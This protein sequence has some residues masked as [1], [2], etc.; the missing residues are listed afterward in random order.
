MLRTR[1]IS[2][3]A[4]M[5]IAL[6]AVY[7]GGI[8]FL[9]GSLLIALIAGWEFSRMMNESGYHTTPLLT[10]TLITLLLL[11]SYYWPY[12]HLQI[13]I[14]LTLIPSLI[15]QLFRKHTETQ[16]AD[17]ALT[18][19]GGFYVGWGMAHLV[20]L[21]QLGDGTIWVCVALLSTW[22]ADT[23][24]YFIGRKFGKHKIWPRHS[25]KKTV[26]GFVGGIGGGIFGALL[27]GVIFPATIAMS[28]LLIIGAIV[29]VV[30]F[31][32]DICESMIK[33]DVGVKDS[34]NLFP[35]HGGF[36]DRIDSLLLVSVVVYYYATW[37]G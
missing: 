17:W 2:G 10:L 16:T 21:R 4:A 33:R 8:W 11:D 25:P 9:V 18:L 20:G 28:S 29:P 23:F 1:L 15:W 27:S 32:G 5:P 31:F 34:S 14:T 7:F 36:L 3:L 22:G 37:I 30:S 35:G 26:E 6:L 12:T 24:A 13:I 19:V